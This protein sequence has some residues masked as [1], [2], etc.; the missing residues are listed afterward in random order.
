MSYRTT[1]D[2]P[3]ENTA[4]LA[5]PRSTS[6]GREQP[7]ATTT[8]TR[9]Y[10]ARTGTA[11]DEDFVR[12]FPRKLAVGALGIGSYLGDCTDEEDERYRASV[13]DAI[14]RGVNVVDTASNYR[15]QRSERA[16]GNAIV[17]AIAAGDVR[18]DELVVCTK[19]GY[20]ALD[21]A[22]PAS[23]EAYAQWLEAELF[24]PGIVTPDELVRGGH[25]I[26]PTFLSHQLAQSR[27]NLGLHTIDVYYLHNP[28]EQLLVHD[29]GA[30]RE[31]I[32]AAFAM[33]EERA[34]AGEIAGYGCATWLGL[35]VSPDHRQ[36]LTLADLVAIARDVGGTA[37]HFRAVQLPISL[38]MQ[39]AARVPT[40]P[41]GKRLVTLLE[42]AHALGLGVVASAPL[43]QGKLA[44]GLPEELHALFPSCTTDAQRALRFAASLPG[45]ATVLAGMRS[46]AHVSENMGA[47]PGAATAD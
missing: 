34:D 12:P 24:A 18:R 26:S 29:R 2:R 21:G 30:F 41:L 19:G 27:R 17:E 4:S 16:V 46:L 31:Q 42:A 25:S 14:C 38:G 15:C 35:R 45:V 40:Q 22:P 28:E 8:G 37:H 32:V 3:P 1:D 10:V 36:H 9:R 7:Q 33:L 39:E 11:L 5:P 43:M 47:W 6:A 13:R 23:R 44:S 20:V